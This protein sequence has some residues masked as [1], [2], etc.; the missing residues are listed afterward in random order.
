MYMKPLTMLCKLCNTPCYE[1]TLRPYGWMI[2]FINSVLCIGVLYLLN[3]MDLQHSL[4]EHC[5]RHLQVYG[6]IFLG[7][8]FL[9]YNV[10]GKYLPHFYQA[11]QWTVGKYLS[12][13][14]IL[15]VC[16]TFFV[17][18]YKCIAGLYPQT[19]DLHLLTISWHVMI[20]EPPLLLISIGL[21][22]LIN[23]HHT[24]HGSNRDVRQEMETETT[25]IILP[26]YDHPVRLLYI[27]SNR[28]TK[29]LYILDGDKALTYRADYSFQEITSALQL[30]VPLIEC[31]RSQA[32]NWLEV[33][34]VKSLKLKNSL[35]L[36]ENK[37][38]LKV[39]RSYKKRINSLLH[40]DDYH[41]Y[42]LGKL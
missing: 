39:N 5:L 31:S 28:L 23:G 8:V 14:M 38:C 19:F 42:T 29:T 22:S 25:T 30:T 7:S 41:P 21:E 33:D 3:P 2:L 26:G 40:G 35:L 1:L 16:S 32:V 36:K 12:S 6:L 11:N 37:I 24:T 20:V 34:I 27:S 18:I 9:V 17:W 10:L 15:I 4:G 13:I